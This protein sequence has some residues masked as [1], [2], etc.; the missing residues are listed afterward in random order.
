MQLHMFALLEACLAS[1]FTGWFFCQQMKCHLR[2]RPQLSHIQRDKLDLYL[3][4]C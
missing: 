1:A 2:I 4:S 3:L